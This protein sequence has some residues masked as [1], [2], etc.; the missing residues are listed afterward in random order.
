M[1]HEQYWDELETGL[2]ARDHKVFH[3]VLE[4]DPDE[5]RRRIDTDEV[6]VTA[7]AWRHERLS[8]YDE[9]REWLI[10]RADLVVN[11]SN[12]D[13]SE[14]ASQIL[15]AARHDVV[16]QLPACHWRS[17]PQGRVGVCRV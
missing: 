12:L 4:A 3:V 5:V 11:T 16:S 7:K 14:A 15:L 1:L 13:P 6:E 9:A 10:P 17:S 2:V 8:V